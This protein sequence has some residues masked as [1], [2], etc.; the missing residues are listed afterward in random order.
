MLECGD[1]EW[2]KFRGMFL[3]SY[4]GLHSDTLCEASLFAVI[5]GSLELGVWVILG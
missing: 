3:K 5:I 1:S 4:P 2:G